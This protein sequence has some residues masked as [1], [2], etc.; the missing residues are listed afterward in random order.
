[1]GA[2]ISPIPGHVTRAPA[3]SGCPLIGYSIAEGSIERTV[4]A[5]TMNVCGQECQAL[6]SRSS[7]PVV[8]LL[9]GRRGWA[10]IIKSVEEDFALAQSASAASNLWGIILPEIARPLEAFAIPLASEAAV[11]PAVMLR[12]VDGKW[13]AT[14]CALRN[15]RL[16]EAVS[17]RFQSASVTA[18]LALTKKAFAVLL[19]D[20][21]KA[22]GRFEYLCSAG[23][24]FLPV[25]PD[26]DNW[27]IACTW[28]D[29][30]WR[31]R[32]YIERT[33]E[34]AKAHR[35]PVDTIKRLERLAAYLRQRWRRLGLQIGD[36]TDV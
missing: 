23:E 6:V 36:T 11:V 32:D 20:G 31:R 4:S 33:H 10:E 18:L 1:M 8:D 13:D 17:F 14:A 24:Q 2:V 3:A 35:I 7:R 29:W 9:T 30:Q 16:A 12:V 19:S 21:G 34:W 22:R 26:R 15:D 25:S 5:G 28:P 27:E